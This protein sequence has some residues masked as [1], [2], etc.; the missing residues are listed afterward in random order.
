MTPHTINTIAHSSLAWFFSD[1]L[2]Y[3][4]HICVSNCGFFLRKHLEHFQIHMQE[5]S[6]CFSCLHIVSGTSFGN[7]CIH[8]LVL[9]VRHVAHTVH[10]D[11]Q[12]LWFGVS[13]GTLRMQEGRTYFE[14]VWHA[15]E[16][17]FHFKQMLLCPVHIS[18][19]SAIANKPQS[20][21]LFLLLS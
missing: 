13:D 16:V 2:H 19:A 6:I 15:D 21:L 1:C 14:A 12:Y 9:I 20:L 5:Y 3:C 17:T 10:L 11:T 7:L 4:I 8:S 18:V